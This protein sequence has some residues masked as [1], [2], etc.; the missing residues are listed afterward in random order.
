MR[1]KVETK[2]QPVYWLF[3]V[4]NSMWR[5]QMKNNLQELGERKWD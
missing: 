5:F 4:E 1:Y 2:K 3:S